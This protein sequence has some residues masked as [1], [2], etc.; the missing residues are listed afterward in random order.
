[1]LILEVFSLQ[2]KAF[3]CYLTH[4]VRS[5]SIMRN[6]DPLLFRLVSNPTPPSWNRPTIDMAKVYNLTNASFPTKVQ[7]PSA[8]SFSCAYPET[9]GARHFPM[10]KGGGRERYTTSEGKKASSG[11]CVSSSTFHNDEKPPAPKGRHPRETTS[12][13]RHADG[14][15]WKIPSAVVTL[16]KMDETK[17]KGSA[18]LTNDLHARP[19]CS[20]LV[21]PTH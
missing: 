15:R 8:W 2:P 21:P 5:Y 7:T 20:L 12:L 13:S 9:P 6:G 17:E 19:R 3:C 11:P 1:M 18:W 10:V 16:K 14:G 4:L